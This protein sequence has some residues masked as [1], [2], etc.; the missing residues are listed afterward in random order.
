MSN[1][2][3]ERGGRYNS[4]VI[5]YQVVSTQ[6]YIQIFFVP[7]GRLA[8]VTRMH[9]CEFKYLFDLLRVYHVTLTSHVQ[10]WYG[11]CKTLALRL[12]RKYYLRSKNKSSSV[13]AFYCWSFAITIWP[14]NS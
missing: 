9:S 4:I 14:A 7:K 3:G 12:Q 13:T 8:A 6:M 10:Y 5:F 1:G 11:H 2:E